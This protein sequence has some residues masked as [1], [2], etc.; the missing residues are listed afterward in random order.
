M[1]RV[2]ER[3]TGNL[4]VGGAITGRVWSTNLSSNVA[5][6]ISPVS[7]LS[8]TVTSHGGT[9]VIT[10]K[11]LDQTNS[12]NENRNFIYLY[13]TTS[14]SGYT[15]TGSTLLDTWTFWQS[16]NGNPI[17]ESGLVTYSEQLAAG[18]LLLL[19]GGILRGKRRYPYGLNNRHTF[20]SFR[21]LNRV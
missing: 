15:G 20:D 3:V 11:V 21:I 4:T 12:N 2:P 13:R 9:L 7:L 16:A 6:G 5:Y 8:T 18:T 14:S 19:A 10:G 17:N 1:L